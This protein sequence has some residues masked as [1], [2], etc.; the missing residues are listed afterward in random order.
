[1]FERF[2]ALLSFACL[3]IP[4]LAQDAADV[5]VTESLPQALFKYVE[6]PEPD[7]A[8][9]INESIKNAS[10]EIHQATLVSQ[11]WHDIT[12][13]HDLFVYEPQAVR[14]PTKVLLFITGGSNGRKPRSS[15]IAIGQALANLSGA[16]VAALHQ[17]PNQPLFDGRYE[18]DAI[19]ETWLKYLKTGDE[20]WP[21]LF[22]MVKSAVKAMDAV[23]EMASEHRGVKVD[24]FVI[25]GASKRGWTSWL[26]PV[27]DDRIIGTAPMVIDMLNMRAQ[28]K[29]QKAM[30]GEF[31]DSI[32]DYTRKGL[33]KLESESPRERQLRRMMDPYTYRSRLTLPKLIVNGANDPYW[34][35]D[36]LN[37]YWDG[38][39]GDDNHV[40]QLP[41][42]GHGLGDQGELALRSIA[43]FF[44]CLASGRPFPKLDWSWDADT[45]TLQMSA[46]PM[47]K[48]VRIW[49]A[50]SDDQDFRNDRFSATEL[51]PVDGAYT[52]AIEA[53]EGKHKVIFAEAGYEESG[54]QYSQTTQIWRVN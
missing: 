34:C 24:G 48:T 10:G 3:A 51:A 28:I 54:I 40:L 17:V 42:A 22:P 1:M 13:K 11:K 25:T 21:L 38:L 30:W 37:N 2:L 53:E 45:K 43:V 52:V 33:V 7:Y 26:T 50:V 4:G 15:E 23:Q 35:T 47:P 29:Y 31:S 41:N 49:T 27:V 16:R 46:D 9:T 18:D 44:D 19:T 5:P 14:H 8:W 36:A 20:T 39:E 6:R 12:W 32:R